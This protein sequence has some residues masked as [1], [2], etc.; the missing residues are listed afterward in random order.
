MAV[1]GEA[2][3]R[4]PFGIDHRCRSGGRPQPREEKI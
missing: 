2:A 1:E 3:M 4:C